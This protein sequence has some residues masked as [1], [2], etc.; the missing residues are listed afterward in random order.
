[1][2][3]KKMKI[4]AIIPARYNS[5]RFKGKPLVDILGKTMINR[6]YSQVLKVKKFSEVIVATDDERVF[7]SCKNNNINVIMTGDCNTSTERLYEVSKKIDADYYVCINGDEPLI[8]PNVISKIIPR[9]IEKENYYVSNLITKISKPSEVVDFTNIKVVKDNN[10][11]ALYYSR[12]PIP[13]P[14]SYLDYDY[15]KHL[16]VLCYNKEALKFFADT[17]KGFNEKIEDI[18]ELRFL[19]NG[20][21]IKLVEVKAE[22]LSVDTPKDL[23]KVI[24]IL[25][26]REK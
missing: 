14:K 2:E 23:E 13:Y 20:I 24:D 7:T 6:V 17:K 11:N 15:F 8:S 10:G 4:I 5:S 12:S 25:K 3:W 9:K 21:S 18:N 22:V 26:K 19:E 16:G 1:M